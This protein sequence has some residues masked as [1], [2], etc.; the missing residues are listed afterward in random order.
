MN[1]CHK[2][3]MRNFKLY[4]LSI[5]ITEILAKGHAWNA[6][7]NPPSSTHAIGSQLHLHSCFNR[8]VIKSN[9]TLAALLFAMASMRSLHTPA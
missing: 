1:M 2:T 9:R 7:C 6:T 4:I 3:D 5:D 8:R